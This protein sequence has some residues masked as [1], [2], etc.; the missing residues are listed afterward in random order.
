MRLDILREPA[1]WLQVFRARP[2]QQHRE[3]FSGTKAKHGFGRAFASDWEGKSNY[4][5]Q[6]LW[7]PVRLIYT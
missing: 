4:G 5:S 7:R 2:Y 6:I 1:Q 3:L